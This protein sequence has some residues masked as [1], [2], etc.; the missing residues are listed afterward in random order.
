M[1]FTGYVQRSLFAY[2]GENLTLAVRNNLFESLMHKQIC[3][4]D[5]KDKAPGI[6]SNILSED[7]TNLNGLTTETVGVLLESF[8]GLIAGIVVSAIFEWRMAIVCI[9]MTPFIIVGAVVMARIKYRT[10]PG[11]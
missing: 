5:R 2:T 3:W 7:I 6:L 11:G 9:F 4:Y 10:A 1:G 8:I